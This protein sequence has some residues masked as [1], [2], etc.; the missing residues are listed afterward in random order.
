M[1][2]W[3][4][5]MPAADAN[6]QNGYSEQPG[7]PLLVTQ[8]EAGPPL[9]RG[10]SFAVLQIVQC[11]YLLDQATDALFD[12]YHTTT[13]RWGALPID[14]W[15]HPRRQ[16][17]VRAMI[18]ANDLSRSSYMTMYIALTFSKVYVLS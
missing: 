2:S 5:Y 18:L 11:S 1:P 3:P 14:D 9:V 16:V 7:S 6:L 15:P 4:S 8:V 10:R 13:L 12:A 17:P